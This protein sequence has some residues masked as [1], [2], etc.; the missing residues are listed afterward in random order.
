M[1]AWMERY[2]ALAPNEPSWPITSRPENI[3][4]VVAGGSHPTHAFWMQTS[5]ARKMTSA[6]VRL[7]AA[8]DEL[9]A[10]GREA[11]GYEGSVGSG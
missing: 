1:T 3:A 11:L 6:Q 9:I 2:D 5:I 4:I 10:Q 7:P 8:W